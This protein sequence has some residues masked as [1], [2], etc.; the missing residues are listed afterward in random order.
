[1]ITELEYS[2]VGL[3]FWLWGGAVWIRVIDG[4]AP[5]PAGF[6]REDEV[7]CREVPCLMGPVLSDNSVVGH[8]RINRIQ[9][10]DAR[11]GFE[12]GFGEL[13]FRKRLRL[14]RKVVPAIR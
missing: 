4:L 9:G 10:G 5:W 2:G 12:V 14:A 11:R 6:R 7:G 13:V 8:T 1:L 3:S